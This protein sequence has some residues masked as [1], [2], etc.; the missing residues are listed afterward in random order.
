MTSYEDRVLKLV[1]MSDIHLF[2]KGEIRKELDTAARFTQAI[3]DADRLYADADLCVFAGDIADSAEVAAYEQFDHIRQ[4]FSVPQRVMLGNHDD[5]NVYVACSKTPMLDE[6]GFVQGYEDIK[7]HR[8]LMLDT[9]EPDMHIRYSLLCN[10]R[11][12]WIAD[13]L[14][15]AKDLELKV[16]I[17]LHHNPCAFQMPV[18]TYRLNEPDRLLK[19]LKESG[20][21]IIQ[22]L[23]GHCHI[24]TAGSWGGYPCAT[25]K[26][27]Q[28]SVEPY[29]RGRTEQQACYSSPAQFAVILSDTVNCAVHF[30]DY[31]NT[32][33]VMDPDLFPHKAN[34]LFEDVDKNYPFPAQN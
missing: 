16:I 34:Q 6:N 29:F 11:L 13:R 9:S 24:T 21:D 15:E 26:G 30:H 7:G 22:I 32:A 23:A 5:R 31:L 3:D 10:K 1:V 18:D 19:V 28:H 14:A 2:P 25:I 12:A 20:A 27:N 4:V 8:I 17:L 33:T